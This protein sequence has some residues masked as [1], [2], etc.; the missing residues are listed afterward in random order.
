MSDATQA[1]AIQVGAIVGAALKYGKEYRLHMGDGY[2]SWSRGG[3][4][5]KWYAALDVESPRMVFLDESGGEPDREIRS[6]DTVVI[7]LKAVPNTYL[8]CGNEPVGGRQ[9]TW[10]IWGIGEPRSNKKFLV[11]DDGT[12]PITGQFRIGWSG[13]RENAVLKRNGRW[14]VPGARADGLWWKA[15]P[16]PAA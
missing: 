5:F 11:W 6:G 10:D 4:P 2:L 3:E 14:V 13:D 15:I 7:Q 9:F 12:E 1:D 16:W 8:H